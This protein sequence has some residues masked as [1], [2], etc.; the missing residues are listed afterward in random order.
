M[1]IKSGGRFLRP[2][3]FHN[4]DHISYHRYCPKQSIEITYKSENNFY[5]E[6]LS[7]ECNISPRWSIILPV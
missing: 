2:E 6:V 7:L 3:Q 4:L 1:Q 5:T